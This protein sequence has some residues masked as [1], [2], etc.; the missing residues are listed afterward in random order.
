LFKKEVPPENLIKRIIKYCPFIKELDNA[1]VAG[2]FIRSYYAREKASDMDI[3]FIDESSFNT[4]IKKISNEWEMVSHTSKA[5]TFV[6]QGKVVQFISLLY[7]KEEDVLSLFDFTI[8]SI[9]VN[10]K[11]NVLI[12]HD[13]FF[14]HLAGKELVVETLDSPFSSLLRVIKYIKKG[15]FISCEN[16]ARIVLKCNDKNV[17]MDTGDDR[18]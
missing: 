1:Y 15:Y 10:I 8:C 3:F 7:G 6:N 16:L 5:V 14:E 17:Y 12:L 2:G 4:A 9:S 11:S 13:K 18:Y